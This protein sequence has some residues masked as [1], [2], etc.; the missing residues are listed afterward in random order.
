MMLWEKP[1]AIAKSRTEFAAAQ[2]T[3]P[4]LCGDEVKLLMMKAE[5]DQMAPLG[6]WRD[7]RALHPFANSSEALKAV[8]YLTNFGDYDADRKAGLYMNA[9]LHPLDRFFQQVRRQLSLLEIP[10]ATGSKFGR[11][12]YGYSAYPPENM[13]KVL[14]IFRAYYNYCLAGKDGL[15]LAMRLGFARAAVDPQEII[16]YVPN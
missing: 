13:E 3:H 1:R 14:A 12:W 4:G 7:K 6:A 8:C 10:I 5:I 15:T 16:Y 11:T 2:E 9:T